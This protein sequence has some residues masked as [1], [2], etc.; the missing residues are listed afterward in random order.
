MRIGIVTRPDPNSLSI[1]AAV[2]RG[3][4]VAAPALARALPP[5]RRRPPQRGAHRADIRKGGLPLRVRLAEVPDRVVL[6]VRLPEG[7]VDRVVP[8]PAAPLQEHLRED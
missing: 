5:P 8:D 7:V 2:P 1:R 6:A 4:G 3:P